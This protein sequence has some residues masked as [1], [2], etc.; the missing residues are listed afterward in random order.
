MT[1]KTIPTCSGDVKP[2]RACGEFVTGIYVN[3]PFRGKRAISKGGAFLQAGTFDPTNTNESLEEL[4][5]TF[6]VSEDES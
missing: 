4:S 1:Q 6:G 5:V 3:G 2:T